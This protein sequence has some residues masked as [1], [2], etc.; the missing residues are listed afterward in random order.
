MP[1]PSIR[2]GSRSVSKGSLV[3]LCYQLAKHPFIL[4]LS[5]EVCQKSHHITEGMGVPLSTCPSCSG[6]GTARCVHCGGTGTFQ[7]PARTLGEWQTFPIPQS[8]RHCEGDGKIDCP[9]CQGTGIAAVDDSA[10]GR[11]PIRSRH[12]NFVPTAEVVGRRCSHG[13]H[14]WISH[15]QGWS[16]MGMCRARFSTD[17]GAAIMTARIA[18]PFSSQRKRL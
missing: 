8:C 9:R 16:I 2:C 10:C 13:L 12:G 5:F 1:F 3:A 14:H 11:C 18:L 17:P 15:K 7:F 4:P 6:K